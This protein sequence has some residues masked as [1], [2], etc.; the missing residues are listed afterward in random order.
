MVDPKSVGSIHSR[1]PPLYPSVYVGAASQER[2]LA[3]EYAEKLRD[4]GARITYAWWETMN[5]E[6]RQDGELPVE[7]ARRYT[8]RN[9]F[10]I[11]NAWRVWLLFPE[12]PIISRGLCGEVGMC[13]GMGRK[14]IVSGPWQ[15]Y[16]F[17]SHA[18][19]HF[20]THDEALA[21]LIGEINPARR[22]ERMVEELSKLNTGDET[23]MAELPDFQSLLD[24]ATGLP[25]RF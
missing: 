7:D 3:S 14:F 1:F 4:A 10:G 11:A 5:G 22:E 17:A 6:K 25:R 18:E 21:Y 9:V 8:E 15:D 19:K 12:L 16:M 23:R 20:A 2:R 13:I 24:L